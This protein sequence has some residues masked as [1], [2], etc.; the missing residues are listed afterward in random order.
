[1]IIPAKIQQS[2]DL[3]VPLLEQLRERV[4][5]SVFGYCSKKGFAYS[6][7]LKTP[8]SLAEK[9][10]SGRYSRFSE[11]DDLFGCVVVIPTLAD[12]AD[13]LA[14]LT[15][16]FAEVNTAHRGT[17]YKPPD[18]FRFDSTRFYGKLKD[19]PGAELPEQLFGIIFEVQIRT[20]FEHAWSVTTHALTY[21]SAV[22]HWKR[23]RLTAQLKAAVEQLDALVAGFEESAEH[24]TESEWPEVLA[25]TQISELF[26]R[27]RDDGTELIPGELMP[28]DMSRFCDNVYAMFRAS[29]TWPRDGSKRP[30]YVQ[31][32][33]QILADEFE[34]LSLSAFPR[35][36]SLL[37]IVLG[38]LIE[39]K[40]L[41]LPFY[42]MYT[43]VITDELVDLYPAV[44]TCP[45]RFEFDEHNPP[46][47]QT[48]QP[49]ST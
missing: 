1:M 26:L 27:S 40:H 9:L 21:K 17:S 12:E 31:D 5:G 25:K 6:S 4:E 41:G 36:L 20:A 29:R 14:F 45:Q 34:S 35:S 33:L 22:V 15:A 28:K 43:P 8:E 47:E 19:V 10:E 37:Q 7:R 38:V 46:G 11:I 3:L 32:G 48:E 49:A 16:Q 18:T 44:G 24:V 39:K 23:L 42:R 30:Q 13:V 2:F